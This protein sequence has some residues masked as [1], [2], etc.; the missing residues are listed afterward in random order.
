MK[1]LHMVSGS[2]SVMVTRATDTFKNNLMSVSKGKGLEVART[3][4][5]GQ[6]AQA[7]VNFGPA[8]F[9]RLDC[10]IWESRILFVISTACSGGEAR[11]EIKYSTNT[12]KCAVLKLVNVNTEKQHDSLQRCY[13][14]V[15]NI[16]NNCTE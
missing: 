15:V 9:L 10:L 6:K 2:K 16:D 5:T 14:A 8:A 3:R 4:T 7:Q 13:H 12:F 1:W 11:I